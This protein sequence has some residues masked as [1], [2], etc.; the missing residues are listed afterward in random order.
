MDKLNAF[1][2]GGSDK[3]FWPHTCTDRCG[4]G[5]CLISQR[6]VQLLL[7]G[8]CVRDVLFVLVMGLFLSVPVFALHK[9]VKQHL[10][11]SSLEF[12]LCMFT[13]HFYIV[14]QVHHDNIKIQYIP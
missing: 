7:V 10:A 6:P 3:D 2:V 4:C 13:R 1:K 5:H 9:F 11:D 8:G 12:Y 14:L